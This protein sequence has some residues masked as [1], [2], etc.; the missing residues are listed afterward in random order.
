MLNPSQVEK[1][2]ESH[3]ELCFYQLNNKKALKFNKKTINGF[4]ERINK[5]RKDQEKLLDDLKRKKL[6]VFLQ[7]N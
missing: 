3:P 2:H 1:I 4:K 6:K 5:D 7:Q